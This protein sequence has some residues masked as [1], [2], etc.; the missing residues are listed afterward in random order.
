MQSLFPQT[1]RTVGLPTSN[2]PSPGPK[3]HP[4]DL[5]PALHLLLT[6]TAQLSLSSQ[7][8]PLGQV[9]GQ[10]AAEGGGV[11]VSLRNSGDN[12]NP[13][14]NW[15][16]EELGR[17]WPDHAL[18]TS[19]QCFLKGFLIKVTQSQFI[20]GRGQ[21]STTSRGPGPGHPSSLGAGMQKF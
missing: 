17:N 13:E 1:P 8:R 7:P 11:A 20:K 12:A 6:V 18:S 5:H 16:R 14:Q 15:T 2:T 3:A 21:N 19:T 4:P 9:K 10:P